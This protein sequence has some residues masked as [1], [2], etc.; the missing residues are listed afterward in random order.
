[1]ILP[2]EYSWIE[3]YLNNDSIWLEDSVNWDETFD[4]VWADFIW[5][6]YFFT[7]GF[8]SN[9]IS[10][11]HPTKLSFIDLWFL[12]F[13]TL[14][15]LDFELYDLFIYD[16]IMNFS[17]LNFWFISLFYTEYQDTLMLILYYS[18]ELTLALNDAF[19]YLYHTTVF[20]YVVNS[21]SDI[22]LDTLNSHLSEFMENFI[23]LFLYVW[24]LIF[25]LTY[26]RL[27]NWVKVDSHSWT[28]FFLYSFSLARDTRIQ[29]EVFLQI[30]FFF[31]FY[32]SISLAAFDDDQED[33]LEFFNLNCF[34]F[35]FFVIFY[36]LYKYSYHYFAF[37]ELSVSD[38]RTTSFITKQF[39]RDISNT[40]AL[41]LRFFILLFR[42][43]VYD[44]LDDFYDSYYFFVG[45]YDDDEYWEELLV[46]FSGLTFYDFDN[47]DDRSFLLHDESDIV[48]DG[49]YLYFLVWGKLFLFIFFIIEEVLRLSLA[50]YI[51]YL[52]TFE[53][54]AVNYSYIED[55]FIFNQRLNNKFSSNNT[56]LLT[57]FK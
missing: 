19:F 51:C 15:S 42:L 46:P 29:V 1:M 14:W 28:R 53:V 56:S 43:N 50:F 40:F 33:F 34:F 37:L 8:L 24:L 57:F 20:N 21:R 45:D 6:S 13:F 52:I 18:P 55:N 9:L 5:I 44:G 35:F 32:W 41:L 38:G 10:I 16:R 4:L 47:E 11:Y 26:F 7:S 36:L 12:N 39:V 31:F 3:V 48:M 25:S 2:S 23:M 22:Y 17:T 54:H 27:I 30:L 49:F